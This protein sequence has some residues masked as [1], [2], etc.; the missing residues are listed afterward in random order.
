MKESKGISSFELGDCLI[1]GQQL[2][3]ALLTVDEKIA[4]DRVMLAILV[5]DVTD[6]AV[7]GWRTAGTE[8]G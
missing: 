7:V 8:N 1:V 5:G 6:A 3:Q 2:A 4:R